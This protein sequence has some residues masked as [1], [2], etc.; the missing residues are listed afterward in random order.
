MEIKSRVPGTIEEI[1]V[2][3]GDAVAVKDIL[4]KLEAMK[5]MQPVLAPAAG[6]VEE[7]LVEEGE[8]VKSGQV[9]MRI[10]EE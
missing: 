1:M 10:E 6:T 3:E 8:R 7:I 4:V 9:I 2:K 5:M